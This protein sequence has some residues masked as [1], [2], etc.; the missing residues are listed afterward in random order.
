MKPDITHIN[1]HLE[2]VYRLNDDFAHKGEMVSG[3]ILNFVDGLG[4]SGAP[5]QYYVMVFLEDLR[6]S[7]SED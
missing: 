4:F 5:T 7:F 1:E 2:T 3:E 6:D